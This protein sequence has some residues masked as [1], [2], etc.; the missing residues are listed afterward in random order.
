MNNDS[1]R[2]GR[3]G[4]IVGTK[5]ASFH[6]GDTKS[7]SARA[8]SVNESAEC[9]P[10]RDWVEL[11]NGRE[12]DEDVIHIGVVVADYLKSIQGVVHQPVTLRDHVLSRGY[13]L[14]QPAWSDNG[15]N[16]VSFVG[17]GA[18]ADRLIHMKVAIL[19]EDRLDVEFR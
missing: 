5:D 11:E 16:K 14:S 15:T 2:I 3:T 13:V 9:F 7:P 8:V 6:S 4:F 17:L 12:V 1:D 18:L 19:R 10:D